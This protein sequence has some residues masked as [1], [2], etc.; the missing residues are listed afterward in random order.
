MWKVL[1]HSPLKYLDQHLHTCK[2]LQ[3][4]SG[5]MMRFLIT[6][7]SLSCRH[8]H[9]RVPTSRHTIFHGDCTLSSAIVKRLK[10]RTHWGLPFPLTWVAQ[11]QVQCTRS[12]RSASPHVL[13]HLQHCQKHRS[14]RWLIFTVCRHTPSRAYKIT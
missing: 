5:F 10:H 9:P 13:V 7:W 2:R 1:S 6:E 4:L 11:K 14:L 8:P 3:T 12:M